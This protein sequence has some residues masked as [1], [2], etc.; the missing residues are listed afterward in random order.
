M[1]RTYGDMCLD[2]EGC[3]WIFTHSTTFTN[4]GPWNVQ[5]FIGACKLL[6]PQAN[7]KD[8]GEYSD[9]CLIGWE[10]LEKQHRLGLSDQRKE[11]LVSEGMANYG[12]LIHKLPYG[13][14]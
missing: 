12:K 3:H 14:F 10:A 5:C 4:P 6:A 11:K 7:T 13:K 9:E 2:N 1:I 8:C